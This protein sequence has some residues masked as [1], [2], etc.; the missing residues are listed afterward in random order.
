MRKIALVATTLSLVLLSPNIQAHDSITVDAAVNTLLTE[1]PAVETLD[2][3]ASYMLGARNG[4]AMN[5]TDFKLDM[6][7]YITGL[8]N[9]VDQKEHLMT[10]DQ[11]QEVTRELGAIRQKIAK[12]QQQ[13]KLQ[14]NLKAAEDFLAANKSKEGVQTTASGLQY[15]VITAGEGDS[16]KRES[17]VVVN[18]KGTLIDGTEF[19]SSYKR[20]EP[21]TFGVGQVIAGWTEGLQLMKPGSKFEFYIHPKLAYGET[22]KS[23]IPANSLLIFEVELLEVK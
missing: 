4:R 23:S 6:H 18:Y 2:Q 15:K 13:K 9:S 16:P 3:K 20:N 12:E 17:S 7:A 19:D 14:D 1:K 21:A 5:N 22:P 10:Q 11:M 8:K